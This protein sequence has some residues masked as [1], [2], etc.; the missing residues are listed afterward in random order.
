M[1]N[2][3]VEFYVNST[4]RY[5]FCHGKVGNELSGL[6]VQVTSQQEYLNHYLTSNANKS[7]ILRHVSKTHDFLNFPDWI[8]VIVINNHRINDAIS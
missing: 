8:D 7:Y 1:T 5:W 4:D 6:M 3:L 2:D